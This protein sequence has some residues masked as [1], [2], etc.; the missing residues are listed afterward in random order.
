VRSLT[1]QETGSECLLVSGSWDSTVC[2]WDLQSGV[3]LQVLRGHTD[4]VTAVAISGGR[5]PFVVSGSKD[6]S[7]RVWDISNIRGRG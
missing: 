7:V 5:T 3:R 1:I 6:W 2:L 4:D